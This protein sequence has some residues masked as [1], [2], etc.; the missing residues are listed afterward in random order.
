[1]SSQYGELRSTDGWDRL[2]SLADHSKFQ[3][4]SRIGSVTAAT[5]LNGG[6][7]NFARCL[8]ESWAATLYI[9]FRG[10]YPLTE[11]CQVQNSL[12]VQV[13]RSPIL[14]AWL[15]GA[16][17]LGQW[18]SGAIAIVIADCYRVQAGSNSH[19][20]TVVY[21]FRSRTAILRSPTGIAF[22][23]MAALHSRCGQSILPL[24]VVSS[25]SF[26]YPRLFSAVAEW[27]ST[28]LPHMVWP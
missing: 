12:R 21:T 6:Q 24:C 9:H 14:A 18:S 7:P 2:A 20:R 5:S 1:M 8:A 15:D 19:Y 25:S 4:V 26:F 23:V 13:L 27:M 17:L 22:L 11:V 3:R 28:I 16:Q 10:C